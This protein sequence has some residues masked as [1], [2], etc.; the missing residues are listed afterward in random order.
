MTIVSIL[1]SLD[2]SAA[3]AARVRLA[4]RLAERFDATLTGVAARKLPNPGPGHDLAS[5]QAAYEEEQGRLHGDLTRCRDIFGRSSGTGIRTDLLQAEA[6]P[7]DFLVRQACV[8]DLVVVGR[9]QD[10]QSG[11]LIASPGAVLMEVGRPVLMT[12]PGLDQ[13]RAER[14]VVAWKDAPETRRAVSGALPFLVRAK[15]V[16]V[17]S[18]GEEARFGGVDRVSDFL[19]RHGAQARHH[20]LG[21]TA[22]SVSDEILHFVVEADADLVI[23]GAYGRSRLREWLFGGVTRD[24][25]RHAPVCCLMSH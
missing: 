25:M 9:D 13:L 8:A 16:D 4:A 22:R 10:G 2:L 11:G 15:Q 21:A 23:M 7:A 20:L 19:T 12:P 5:V 6:D 17:V 1:V 3:T 24:F 14:I 18:A